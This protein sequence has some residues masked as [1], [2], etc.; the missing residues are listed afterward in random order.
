MRASHV[1]KETE[2]G[3]KHV[4]ETK[5]NSYLTSQ[6]LS[7]KGTVVNRALPSLLGGVN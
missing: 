5:N 1:H 7:F 4:K 3:N 2:N 6:S